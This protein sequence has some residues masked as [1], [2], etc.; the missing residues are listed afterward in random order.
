MT[1]SFKKIPLES[2][3]TEQKRD[4][5]DRES[6]RNRLRYADREGDRQNDREEVKKERSSGESSIKVRDIEARLKKG[7]LESVTLFSGVRRH[8]VTNIRRE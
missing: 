4:S 5:D 8:L 3:G 6:D 1:E 7:S 2:E